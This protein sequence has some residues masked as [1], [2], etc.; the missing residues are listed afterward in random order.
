M[1]QIHHN[2][3]NLKKISIII[4]NFNSKNLLCD[5]ITSIF[6][7][8]GYDN[9]EIIVVDNGSTDNSLKLAKERF[10]MIK[11][12]E[13]R[14]NAGFAKANN[15]GINN[16]CG[17]YILL[18]NPDTVIKE[19]SILKMLEYFE[20]N[21]DVGILGPK[22]LNSN[23]TIQLSCRSFPK[24][25]NAIFNRYSP[26]TLLFPKN[27][28]SAKYLYSDWVHDQPKE[29]DWVSGACLLTKKGILAQTG[30]LDENFFMYCE[31]IDLCFRVKLTGKKVL[32]FPQAVVM[33]HI[34]CKNN[35]TTLE[36]I[37]N[38]HIS[39]YKFFKKHYGLNNHLYN[40]ITCIGMCLSFLMMVIYRKIL[41]IR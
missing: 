41:N 27:R 26:I 13:N 29:V 22:L 25:S 20:N 5:C 35:S 31:D 11:F 21:P 39:M 36:S 15:I 9:L 4:V 3:H 38:H 37:K 30:L 28:F 7:C 23:G 32:Y 12:I 34:R 14:T 10:S 40:A 24:F 16:S 19:D 33:H 18:L 1:P 6:N 2:T 17:D 8:S